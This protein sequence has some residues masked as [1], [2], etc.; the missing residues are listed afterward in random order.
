MA[1]IHADLPE[2]FD[3][4][5]GDFADDLSF[6]ESLARRSEGPVLELGVGTG[7]VAIPLARAGWEVWGIDLSEAML[8]RA[9]Y[10][11]GQALVLPREGRLHLLP[12]DMRDF[13]LGRRFDLIFAGLG[14]FHHLLTPDDQRSC[15]R[16]VRR[17]LAP[18][19]LFVCDLR[20]LLFSAWERGASVPLLH[21]WTRVLPSTGE[22]VAKLRSVRADPARQVQ[23]E[24]HIYDR[25]LAD[26]TVRR[27]VATV[28]LRFTTRYE[29]EGL[30]REAGLEL[31]QV[32]GDFDL[33]PYD[34]AS[35]Y[36]IT[37]ARR[38]PSG[39][40]RRSPKEST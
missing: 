8:A 37:V 1:D 30:L 22:T 29:M 4:D 13:E 7:R 28:D 12:G 10:K 25:L 38:S 23:H 27:V 31:D 19:G 18:G 40:R 6:Y 36:L 3:L 9:R 32:Y 15:L 34:D 20:P 2:L 39:R 16:C 5:C 24:T 35:E 17:H 11:T 14:T 33:S 26:G 21:D